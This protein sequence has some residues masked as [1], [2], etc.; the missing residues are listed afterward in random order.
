M[1]PWTMRR[2]FLSINTAIEVVVPFCLLFCATRSLCGLSR[3]ALAGP[4]ALQPASATT[5]SAASLIVSAVVKLRP[6][7]FSISLPFSTFVPSIRM[8]I[9]TG[10]PRSRDRRDDPFRQH[11]A[12]QD[13]AE[14]IDQHR[15]DALVRHQDAERVLDLFGVG[16]AA[17][18]QEVRRLASGQLDDVHRRHGQAGA[19]D[20]AADRAVELDVIQRILRRFDLERI[21]LGQVAHVLDVRV[22]EEGVVVE[23]HLRVEREQVA[24]FGHDQRIDLD[25]RGVGFN[26]GVPHG[27]HQLPGLRDLRA[28]QTERKGEL[29]RLEVAQ[30][31]RRD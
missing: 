16:A 26:E 24:F 19:V 7:A 4:Q 5:R 22:A 30:A 27:G 11:V 17:D 15:L 18:I 23:R 2:V 21:F 31:R 3:L 28:L 8:T 20:H 6:L 25:E 12:A 14:N 9:G 1:I 10:T 29:A 13:A